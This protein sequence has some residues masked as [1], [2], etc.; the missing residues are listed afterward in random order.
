MELGP[1]L[2]G[3]SLSVRKLR[4]YDRV[5]T[6]NWYPNVTRLCLT[7]SD[8]SKTPDSAWNLPILSSLSTTLE[9]LWLSHEAAWAG[10]SG[11]ILRSAQD[12]I[13]LPHLRHIA[14]MGDEPYGAESS[15]AFLHSLSLPS[16][17]SIMWMTGRRFTDHVLSKSLQFP[18][19]EYCDH[20]RNIVISLVRADSSLME[21]DTVFGSSMAIDS[22][23]L[24]WL[25][26]GLP[27]VTSISL[28]SSFLHGDQ[29]VAPSHFTRLIEDLVL[30]QGKDDSDPIFC[31]ALSQL[32]V[33]TGFSEFNLL[34]LVRRGEIVQELIERDIAPKL[35]SDNSMQFHRGILDR[36]YVVHFHHGHLAT[37][38]P[39]LMYT[40]R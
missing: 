8:R 19:Q 17:S 6:H 1:L 4:L 39:K 31:P 10:G 26:T 27:N 22:P 3:H 16:F 35:L 28:P 14:A 13:C 40:D 9:A 36:N 32:H 2:N 20:V 12:Q 7:N 5:F 34:G 23:M 25:C 15:M 30:Y 33:Y 37:Q 38:N 21:G 11:V 18:P 29:G 24:H